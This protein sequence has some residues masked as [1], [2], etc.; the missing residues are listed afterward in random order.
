MTETFSPRV[1]PSF[2]ISTPTWIRLTFWYVAIFL[3]AFTSFCIGSHRMGREVACTL[4][5]SSDE[6]TGTWTAFDLVYSCLSHLAYSITP[7]TCSEVVLCRKW[8]V[9]QPCLPYWDGPAERLSHWVFPSTPSAMSAAS[10]SFWGE[11][12]LKMTIRQRRP[13]SMYHT[14]WRSLAGQASQLAS[15]ASSCSSCLSIASLGM[16]MEFL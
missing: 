14:E 6:A 16:S 9:H 11:T 7:W 12:W 3:A 5:S 13:T 15:Q 1:S 4:D 8:Q 2:Y 10:L